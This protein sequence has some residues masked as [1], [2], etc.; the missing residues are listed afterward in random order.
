MITVASLLSIL[1]VFVLCLLLYWAAHR[2]ADAFGAPAP[3]VAVLDVILVI[4]FVLWLLS[5]F[6]IGRPLL[7]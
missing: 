6:G 4:V 7:R 1:L 3:V 5:V 2:L